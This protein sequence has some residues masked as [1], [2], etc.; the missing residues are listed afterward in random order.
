M[1]WKYL[2]SSDILDS[3]KV[4]SIQRDDHNVHHH[5]LVAENSEENVKDQSQQFKHEVKEADFGV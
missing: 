2:P 3:P 5:S 1:I 4:N